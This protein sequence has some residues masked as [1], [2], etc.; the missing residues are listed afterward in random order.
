MKDSELEKLEAELREA[1]AEVRAAEAAWAKAK[2][3][4][5]KEWE[6]EYEFANDEKRVKESISWQRSAERAFLEAEGRKHKAEDR[7]KATK[8]KINF[9]KK[10]GVQKDREGQ[11]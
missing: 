7:I 2:K 5:Y 9:L 3:S 6:R 8:E 4:Y 1:E 11:T 10:D